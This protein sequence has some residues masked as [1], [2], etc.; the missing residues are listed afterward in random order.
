MQESSNNNFYRLKFTLA[1]ATSV[2]AYTWRFGRYIP[3]I[4]VHTTANL[5]GS[6]GGPL[7]SIHL[8]KLIHVIKNKN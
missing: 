4:P 5:S 3:S 2:R 6:T 8:L 1:F 7:F